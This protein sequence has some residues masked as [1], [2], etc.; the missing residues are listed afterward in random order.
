MN[1]Y[2]KFDGVPDECLGA[3]DKLTVIVLAAIL[4]G[5]AV[6]VVLLPFGRS[7]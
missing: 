4:I 7:M 1:E 2:E 6:A 3:T 5:V